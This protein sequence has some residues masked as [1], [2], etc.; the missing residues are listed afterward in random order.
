MNAER[1]QDRG[2]EDPTQDPARREDV[3]VTEP[4]ATAPDSVE[5]SVPE[6]TAHVG[7]TGPDAADAPSAARKAHDAAPGAADRPS[8]DG[9]RSNTQPEPL[10][11][12]DGPVPASDGADLEP[13]ESA[14]VMET[15]DEARRIK[16]TRDDQRDEDIISLDPVD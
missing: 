11:G 8:L 9:A 5:E 1:E 4:T 15:R 3:P 13:G 12:G 6:E 7:K 14:D 2:I 10:A 16:Q